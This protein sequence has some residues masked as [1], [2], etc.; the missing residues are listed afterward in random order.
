MELRAWSTKLRAKEQRVHLFNVREKA[1]IILQSSSRSFMSSFFISSEISSSLAKIMI[2]L[3][4]SNVDL[5]AIL[6][7][8][9]NSLFEV[10][11]EPSVQPVK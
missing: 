3:A 7:N 6:R 10:L 1:V 2:M 4:F 11:P 8:W 9:I 5:L